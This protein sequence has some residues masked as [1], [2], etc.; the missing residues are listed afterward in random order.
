MAVV[1]VGLSL[2]RWL[3]SSQVAVW[4]GGFPLEVALEDRSGR[5]IVA[6][7]VEPVPQSAEARHFLAHPDS[8]EFHL[9]EVNWVAGQAFTVW[10][11]S[12][13]T[14]RSGRELSYRHYQALIVRID[15][16]DGTNR[17]F[18]VRIPDG[19]GRLRVSVLVP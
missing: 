18:S 1:A 14:S 3:D 7:A 8:P 17:L 6:V 19:S 5:S 11:P 16:A 4:V 2:C 9:E 15:Y 10:V 12:S 13:G